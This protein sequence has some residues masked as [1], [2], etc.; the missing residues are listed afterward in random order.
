MLSQ[1]ELITKLAALDVPITPQTIR[2]REKLD[3]VPAAF[4]NLGANRP[5]RSAF[6]PD[7]SIW[8]NYAAAIMMNTP[9]RRMTA[10]MVRNARKLA[11]QMA[12]NPEET[13]KMF[14]GKPENELFDFQCACL[15][16]GLVVFS[17]LD[18]PESMIAYITLRDGYFSFP[19]VRGAAKAEPVTVLVN[20]G[21]VSFEILP[22]DAVMGDDGLWKKSIYL[23]TLDG[24]I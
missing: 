6:Y 19:V 13:M 16:L 18:R 3:I 12:D 14:W 24:I 8:E 20:N 5:G 17:Y 1:E 11:Y 10:A 4:R 21:I 2:N 9:K 23:V 7:R 15:W 22:H